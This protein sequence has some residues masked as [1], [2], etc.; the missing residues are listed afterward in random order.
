MVLSLPAIF[1]VTGMGLA[2]V[3]YGFRKRVNRESAN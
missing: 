1:I 2:D 3:W